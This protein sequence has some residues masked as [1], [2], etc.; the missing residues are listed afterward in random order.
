M[1]NRPIIGQGLTAVVYA[2]E[3]GRVIK[4]FHTARPPAKVE[5]EYR[6]ARAVYTAGLPAPAVHDLLEIDGQLGIVMEHAQG[7]SLF[8]QVQARPWKLR[9]AIRQLAELHTQLHDHLAPPELPSQRDWIAGGIESATDL[10]VEEKQRARASLNGLPDG[11]AI[12]HGD[13]H[14]ENIIYTA[15]GPIILDWSRATRGHPHGDVACTCRLI[16][17]APMP[18]WVK[19]HMHLLIRFS[20]AYAHREYVSHYLRLRP[21][22]PDQITAWHI[23]LAVASAGWAPDLD[24]Y[25]AVSS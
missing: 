16:Q 1:Y 6:I 8:Q 10:T 12:C 17:S 7:T 14:P 24:R 2:W 9:A 11:T 23:P 18:S 25:S 13:F 5:L 15:R 4:L 22:S 20:R 21:A 3:P 19:L